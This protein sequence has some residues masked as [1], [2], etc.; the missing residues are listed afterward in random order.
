MNNERDE[1][2]WLLR[3]FL[4][5]MRDRG[6]SH[7]TNRA[8]VGIRAGELVARYCHAVV[9]HKCIGLR[10]NEIRRYIWNGCTREQLDEAILS[11]GFQA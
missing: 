3:E 1:A 4:V 2:F 9:G 5:A 6:S 8:G 7:V 11:G 10:P